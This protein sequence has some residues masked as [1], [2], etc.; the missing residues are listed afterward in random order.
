M[1][2]FP[3]EGELLHYFR[4]AEFGPPSAQV[5][6]LCGS[7]SLEVSEPRWPPGALHSI[8]VR[9]LE[10]LALAEGYPLMGRALPHGEAFTGAYSGFAEFREM[11]EFSWGKHLVKLERQT[12]TPRPGAWLTLWAYYGPFGKGRRYAEGTTNDNT[13]DGALEC[14][15]PEV[16]LWPL[17]GGVERDGE[18]IREALD[19]A[20]RNIKGAR[21]RALNEQAHAL[22]FRARGAYMAAAKLHGALFIAEVTGGMSV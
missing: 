15:D 11:L 7:H 21:R 5:E 16:A 18:G 8:M 17:V 12:S 19:D 4:H 9:A 13:K 1:N 6:I 14:E 20:R 3:H 22:L 2:H 10:R